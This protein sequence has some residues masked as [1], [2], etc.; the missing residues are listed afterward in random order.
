MKSEYLPFS[1]R[2]D[3]IAPAFRND[4]NAKE[5][6]EFLA[7]YCDW[8]AADFGSGYAWET[9]IPPKEEWIKAVVELNKHLE[10]L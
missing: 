4:P 8:A 3:Y 7:T 9:E 5:F 1:F 10:T 2:T 6:N